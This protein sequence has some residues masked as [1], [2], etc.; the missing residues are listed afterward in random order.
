MMAFGVL[1]KGPVG[2]LLPMAVTFL[3]AA[4]CN[5]WR[6]FFRL[7]WLIGVPLFL[8]MT[9]P[10]FVLVQQRNPQFNEFFWYGQN[11]A[12]F[13]GKGKN[14]E[15]VQPM[16]YFLMWLPLT[17]FPWS[18][19]LPGA[20]YVAFARWKTRHVNRAAGIVK[21]REYSHSGRAAI[22]LV[23]ATVF[24]TAFFSISTSKLITYILPALP[25]LSLLVGWYFEG[26]LR[27]RDETRWRGALSSGVILLIA[28]TALVGI[29]APIV[30]TIALR[31]IEH[32]FSL[33][34][35]FMAA[36]L[37]AWCGALIVFTRRRRLDALLI[38][39]AL[40]STALF[41][42]A[43]NIIALVAPNHNCRDLIRALRPGLDRRRTKS[44]Q[45]DFVLHA[46]GRILQ[47]PA[48]RDGETTPAKL[49]F[50]KKPAFARRTRALVSRRSVRVRAADATESSGLFH[51]ERPQRR[52]GTFE[53]ISGVR[54]NRVE[55]AARDSRQRAGD[56][57]HAAAWQPDFARCHRRHSSLIR[58][59][60]R[61][62]PTRPHHV[63]KL[64]MNAT[65]SPP[66][67]AASTRKHAAQR[68]DRA[69][70]RRDS[71]RFIRH[72]RRHASIRGGASQR[73]VR[74]AFQGDQT[75]RGARIFR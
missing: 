47:R 50:G 37:L 75:V 19:F 73:A 68:P 54:G 45:T 64:S 62:P 72:R 36:V 40:G 30:G 51:R 33:W 63:L 43:I 53:E 23:I 6:D 65:S 20:I 71:R 58:E 41:F 28:V 42:G 52:A 69:C 31:K 29:A 16:Y 10:W 18:M 24:I 3:Y 11:V 25:P 5:R 70:L 38:S 34:P 67:A 57:S 66:S 55:Q 48:H 22:Y 8:L 74:R 56:Q 15:H 35:F 4:T 12:R 2:V 32:T 17:F 60:S 59:Y 46:V 61:P 13:L 7:R 44:S 27:A 1:A 26:F 39:T 49:E 9:V 14:R 21:A